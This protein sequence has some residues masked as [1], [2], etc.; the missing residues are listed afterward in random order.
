MPKD[1]KLTEVDEH[2]LCYISQRTKGSVWVISHGLSVGMKN[3]RESWNKKKGDFGGW[4]EKKEL[5]VE[6]FLTSSF[7]S[8]VTNFYTKAY[9]IYY[10]TL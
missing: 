3:L 1:R 2:I 10:C 7:L 8:T 6:N 9:R 5:L 4:R